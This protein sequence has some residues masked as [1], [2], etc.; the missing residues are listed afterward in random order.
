[1]DSV[2][3]GPL[4]LEFGVIL[5]ELRHRGITIDRMTVLCLNIMGRTIFLFLH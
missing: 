2:I 4:H 1:M 5:C 3:G